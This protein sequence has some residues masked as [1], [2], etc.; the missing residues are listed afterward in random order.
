MLLTFDRSPPFTAP[1]P[2]QSTFEP[3]PLHP[4][5]KL[6]LDFRIY[7]ARTIFRF[8]LRLFSSV[9]AAASELSRSNLNPGFRIARISRRHCIKWGV[10]DVEARAMCFVRENTGVPV[11][12]VWGFWS[13]REP[14]SSA[15]AKGKAAAG[16]SAGSALNYML[17]EALP[18][19]PVGDAW[20]DMQEPA[21][22]RFKKEFV[23]YLTEL[24]SLGQPPPPSPTREVDAR[25]RASEPAESSAASTRLLLAEGDVQGRA[26][27]GLAGGTRR[28]TTEMGSIDR[29]E[30]TNSNARGHDWYIGALNH[31]PLTDH[32]IA[33]I[34][35]G[36][37]GDVDSWLN[38]EYL[39]GYVARARPSD[40]HDRLERELT[41][42]KDWKVVFTHSDLTPRNVLVE[43][44]SGRITGFVDWDSA[45]WCVEWW[46]GVKGLYGWS[47]RSFARK[48]A[49]ASAGESGDLETGL[50]LVDTWRGLLRE[51]VGEF[52]DELKADEEM[53]DIYGFPY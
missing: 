46:E 17:I 13:H 37:F 8:L 51:V 21:R 15:A 18:G 35:Y 11:P 1:A 27:A 47:D 44:D 33:T 28:T 50:G 12:R 29:H 26:E 49:E 10:R 48:T 34:P 22:E 32:R 19:E 38:C 3:Q 7:L 42:K 4:A 41:K 6:Y 45:G 43:R 30:R 31:Q 53:R 36:P 52:D 5:H 20:A 24:R 2:L 39:L 23:G 25:S 40:V 9:S 14:A 16:R